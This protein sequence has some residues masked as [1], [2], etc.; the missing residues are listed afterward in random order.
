MDKY[1]VQGFLAQHLA[2]A[3]SEIGLPH[4]QVKALDYLSKCRTRSLGGHAQYCEDGHLNGVWYN[5]CKNRFCPQCR[6]VAT[7]EWLQN[8]QRILLDC[9]HHHV[10]FTLPSELHALWRY[11]RELVADILQS[12]VKNTL[13]TFAE[14]KKHLGAKPGIISVLHTWG[15]DLSLHPHVHTVITH[16]GVDDD[17]EWI[18]PR[19]KSLF[20][21]K[22]VMRVFRG[23]MLSGLKQVLRNGK[24]KLPPDRCAHHIESLFNK[25]GR[26]DWVVHFCERYEHGWGVAKYLS[27]YVKRGPLKS[28]QL[29]RITQETVTFSYSSHVTKKREVMTL[30]I[31]AF[32]ER[33]AQHVPLP[34][35]ATVRYWGIYSPASRKKL[36]LA[37]THMK[38]SAISERISIDSEKYFE[39]K[40]CE[41]P[42]CQL[43][44]KPLLV[45][46][47]AVQKLAA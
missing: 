19:R 29:R 18:E 20:P 9:P 7:E 35:K 40:G 28:S 16:G 15:R 21:Q 42:T 2:D 11:N 34:R 25:L 14:D 31:G 32:I 8:T 22:P 17:G 4:Y 27:R 41:K 45:G 10:V 39:I 44:G 13:S 5:S 1:T 36:N 30:P 33:I 26:R 47:A 23:K 12:S 46:V 3:L 37:R 43:C 38:Q 24:L 6:G